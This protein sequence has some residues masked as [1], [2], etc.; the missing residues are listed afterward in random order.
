M[1]KYIVTLKPE[2]RE[3]LEALVSKGK[4]AAQKVVTALVLLNC[5]TAGQRERRHSSEELAEVLQISSRK[6]DR[7]KRCFVEEGL[8]AVLQRSPS[9]RVYERIV[10]G[11]VEAHLVAL[12]CSEPPPGH[13]RWSLKLLADKAVELQYV[14]TISHETVRRTLK[15]TN[16]SLGKRPVG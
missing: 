15:K 14:E 1:E 8:E 11:D 12:S 10:D 2:E 7:V 4:H 3:Q 16:S 13:A 6:I 9:Q 5:D